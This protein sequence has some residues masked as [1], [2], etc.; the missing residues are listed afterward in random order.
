[1]KHRIKIALLALCAML[2]IAMVGCQ[3]EKPAEQSD[4]DAMKETATDKRTS[5]EGAPFYTL[6]V[7]NDSRTGT[8][9]IN[10]DNYSDGTGRSDT[11][12]LARIDP[13]TYQVTLV[14][15]PRDTAVELDGRTNKINEVY[16]VGGIDALVKE[17]ESLTGVT[18]KYYFDTGFVEFQNLINALGG[19]VAEVPIDMSLKDIV[20]GEKISLGAGSQELDGAESLVLARVRKL[21]ANDHDACRQIQDRQIV[22]VT[23]KQ[24]AANPANVAAAL[25]ALAEHTETNWPASSLKE[26]VTD[27]AEHA[28]EIK[29]VSGTGPYAGDFDESAGG[30]WLTPRDES[31][32]RRVIEVVDAGGD[33]TTVVALPSVAP[34]Q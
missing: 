15:I 21:Y 19:I 31:T 14:T 23:I 12:M 10:N 17:V 24:V 30:L 28:G 26:T 20:G 22:D 25:A 7:G 11:I 27:F 6:I 2:V 9:E 32:W 4:T 18:I 8:I 13:S 33:P 16:R 29:I 5:G 34:A 3:Q 1:M